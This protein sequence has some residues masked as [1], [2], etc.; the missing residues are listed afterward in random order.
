MYSALKDSDSE[1]EEEVVEP[2]VL[3]NVLAASLKWLTIGVDNDEYDKVMQALAIWVESMAKR[4]R[5][6]KTTLELLRF[7]CASEELRERIRNDH[8]TRCFK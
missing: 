5:G 1:D 4:D 2:L 7:M 3:K 6:G 8:G